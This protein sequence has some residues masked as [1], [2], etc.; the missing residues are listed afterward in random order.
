MRIPLF[1]LCACALLLAACDQQTDL[2]TDAAPTLSDAPVLDKAK[3]GTPDG[4]VY[5]EAN[6]NY[7][8]AVAA[9]DGI[10]WSDARAATEGLSYGRCQA[11]LATI[12][13][14]NEND[15]ILNTF[16]EAAEHG[17]WLGG[18]QAEGSVEPGGG[19]M[20]VT[21][22]PFLYTN[23]AGGEPNNLLGNEASLHFLPVVFYEP[24]DPGDA[25]GTWN[26]QNGDAPTFVDEAGNVVVG[27]GGY[28]VEYECPTKVTGGGQVLRLDEAGDLFQR[29]VYGFNGHRNSDTSVKGQAQAV[30]KTT[31]GTDVAFHMDV[32]CLSVWNN[33]AWLGG[34]V[35]NSNDPVVPIGRTYVW[36]IVDN[37]QGRSPD[38]RL[39][40]YVFTILLPSGEEIP[41]DQTCALQP[42][43][44]VYSDQ[45][46]LV[47]G[48]L[49]IH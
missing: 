8:Q 48:N 23:W 25:P 7:Y 15:W 27:V 26:D 49:T 22:E 10:T 38:D 5:N 16:P 47:R 35:R 6:R 28:V 1:T 31:G 4:L 19:W 40:F 34:I 2:L 45:F 3:K 9:P 18:T 44:G 24:G 11:H 39:S 43:G 17:Y 37:G 20:W 29:R 21:G 41:N 30:L 36:R 46:E 33:E 42:T 14:Q 13:S 12:T 32:T